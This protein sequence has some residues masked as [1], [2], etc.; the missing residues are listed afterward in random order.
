M[1]NLVDE[2]MIKY[3]PLTLL[4][5]ACDPLTNCPVERQRI[6]YHSCTQTVVD[7]APPSTELKVFIDC[8]ETRY[9]EP[10]E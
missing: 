5:T 1:G 3:L 6:E 9:C 7:P 10:V 8:K 4:L 2:M